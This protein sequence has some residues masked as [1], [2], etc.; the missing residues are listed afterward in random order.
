MDGTAANN[1]ASQMQKGLPDAGP[2]YIQEDYR[3][4]ARAAI[5]AMRAIPELCYDHYRC[6]KPWRELNSTEVL[7]LWIDAA[8]KEDT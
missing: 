5:N 7:N 2:G 1:F 8:L 4:E 6:D 3:T